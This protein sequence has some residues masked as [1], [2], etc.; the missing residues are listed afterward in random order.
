MSDWRGRKFT[1]FVGCLGVCFSAIVTA[2]SPT[3]SGLVI[4]RFFLAF[5]TTIATTATPMLL[6]EISPP[7]HRATVSGL[8]NTLYYLGSIIAAVTVYGTF[9][10]P[11]LMGR[12]LE[13]RLPLWLQIIC[14]GIVCLGIFFVPESPRWLVSQSRDEEARAMLA[15]YHTPDNDA[16]HPLVRLQMAEIKT[17]LLVSQVQAETSQAKRSS[18]RSSA[19]SQIKTFFSPHLTHVSLL[20]TAPRRRRITLVI[21]FSWI[22]QFSGNNVVSYYLPILARSVGIVSVSTQLLLNVLYAASGWLFAVLGARSHDVFGRRRTF[23][24]ALS[25]MVLFLALAAAMAATYERSLPATVVAATEQTTPPE[26]ERASKAAIAFIFAFG[27][28]FALGFT[29]MQPIYPAELLLLDQRA[30]GLAI[31]QLTS[32]AASFVNTFAAPVA[33]RAVGWWVYVFFVVWDVGEIAVVWAWFVEMG[34]R[35]LEGGTGFDG[36]WRQWRRTKKRTG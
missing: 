21:I 12:L 14:P 35:T 6:V 29:A 32:G 5:F 10:S 31:A 8:Y 15:R 3:F 1:I 9:D 25:C 28:A 11:A 36:G 30:Q 22:S 7:Q 4:A 18:T 26:A 13:W 16:E 24:G 33:L 17:T 27:A 19:L 2:T 20:S 23:L 34:G